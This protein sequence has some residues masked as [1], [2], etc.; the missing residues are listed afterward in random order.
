MPGLEDS[1]L[2]EQHGALEGV[3][4]LADV[5]ITDSGECGVAA[6][7]EAFRG[8][9]YL[10]AKMTDEVLGEAGDVLAPLALAGGWGGSALQA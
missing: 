4:E 6:G 7:V 1:A 5:A 2:A 10:R 8:R 3:R 9:S